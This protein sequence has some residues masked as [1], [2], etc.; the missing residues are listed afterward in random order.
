MKIEEKQIVF[1]ENQIEQTKN[2]RAQKIHSKHLAKLV[3]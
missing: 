3:L 1:F 2:K